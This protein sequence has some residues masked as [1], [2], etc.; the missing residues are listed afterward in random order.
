[1]A[2]SGRANAEELK[3]QRES[4]QPPA[5]VNDFRRTIV[6]YLVSLAGWSWPQRIQ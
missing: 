1:M 4:C 6:G 5:A 2:P 3:D